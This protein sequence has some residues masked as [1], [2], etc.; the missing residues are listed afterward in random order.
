MYL[1]LSLSDKMTLAGYTHAKFVV[2]RHSYQSICPLI[3]DMGFS[4]VARI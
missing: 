3:L 2:V 1:S 4:Q